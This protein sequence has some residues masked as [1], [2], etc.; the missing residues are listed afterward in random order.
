[1]QGSIQPYFLYS[2]SV[3]VTSGV[4]YILLSIYMFILAWED[5]IA[6]ILINILVKT[7]HIE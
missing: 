4:V 7:A 3:A 1:M 6:Y 5:V 2:F